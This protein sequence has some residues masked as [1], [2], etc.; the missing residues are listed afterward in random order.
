MIPTP[1]LFV[2][3]RNKTDVLSDVAQIKIRP[4]QEQ[5]QQHPPS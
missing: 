5:Q 3:I 2:F 4:T 1:P